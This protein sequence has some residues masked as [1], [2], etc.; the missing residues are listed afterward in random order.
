MAE[1]ERGRDAIGQA[2]WRLGGR[3]APAWQPDDEGITMKAMGMHKAMVKNGRL[4]LDEPTDL[5]ENAVVPLFDANPYEHIEA[6]DDL[7]DDARAKLE[8]A[9]DRGWDEIEAGKSYSLDQSLSR[10][11][12][13]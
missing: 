7:D 5:P 10:L 8:A 2:G 11:S 9:L 3:S 12:S 6:F 13:R 4:R 1:V